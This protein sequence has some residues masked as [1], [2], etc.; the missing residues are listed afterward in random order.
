M[1]FYDKYEALCR[2][3]MTSPTK[4]AIDIGFIIMMVF[5]GAFEEQPSLLAIIIPFFAIHLFPLYISPY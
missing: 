2:S 3:R 4:A 5:T 1:G